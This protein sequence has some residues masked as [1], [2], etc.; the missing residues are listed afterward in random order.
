M[1]RLRLVLRLAAVFLLPGALLACGP[2]NQNSTVSTY[3]V[4]TQG[5]VRYG[6]VVG[7]R[8]VQVAGTR[9]GVGTAAGAVGGGLIGGTIGGDWRA[10][11]VGGVAG[12]LLGGVAGTVVEEGVTGGQAVEFI[13]RGDEGG[14]DQAVIQTNEQGLRVGERVAL[15]YTDRVRIARAVNAPPVRYTPGGK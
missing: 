2:A 4:G 11:T 6:T 12:A 14:P 5:S 9:S 13:I 7:M 10:R 15:S 3:A 1:I 8:P